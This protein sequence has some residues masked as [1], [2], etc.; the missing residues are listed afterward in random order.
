[1]V[2]QPFSHVDGDGK[3]RMVDISEKQATRRSADARCTVLSTVGPATLEAVTSRVDVIHAARLAGIQAAKQTANLIP[4]CHPLNLDDI[5]V[6]VSVTARGVD[7]ESTVVT[8]HH[9]GVEMEA[10]TACALAALSIVTSL[11]A[12]DPLAA[13]EDL[14]LMR[15]SGGRSGEWGRLVGQPQ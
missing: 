6:N 13:V 1:V 3:L 15:K 14:V 10:L 7:V 11:L 5:Q 12:V 8:V 9:T 2:E 4:L